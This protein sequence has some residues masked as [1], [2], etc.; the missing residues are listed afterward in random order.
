[1]HNKI[2]RNI[3]ILGF[4]SFFTDMASA[5]VTPLIPVFIVVVLHEG[6]DKLGL[7]VAMATLFS[8]LLRLFSGYISDRYGITKPLVVGGYILSAIS[9]PLLY[10]AHDWQSV[11]LIRSAERIGKGV[12]SA[13][14]DVMIAHYSQAK[15]EGKTFGFHKTL[16]IAGELSGALLIFFI[17]KWV[18]ESEEIIRILFLFTVI[19][20]IISIILMAFFVKD[21]PKTP[22]QE[23]GFRLTSKDHTVIK[24]MSLYFVFIFFAFSD[25][26]FTLRAIDLGFTVGVIPLFFIV[27]IGIQTLFSY[28]IGWLIDR[29]GYKTVFTISMIAG[30]LMQLLLYTGTTLSVWLAYGFFGLF[31]VASLNANRAFI[32]SDSDNKGSVYGIFYAGTALFASA[33]A[34]ISGLIWEE[35]GDISALTFSLTGTVTALFIY[36]I[37]SLKKKNQNI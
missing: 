27:S 8:Y 7:I 10:F 37:L 31:T 3:V 28:P 24:G 14:K 15:M 26:F 20:G 29:V 35:L 30:V 12:R 6:I 2:D 11:A 4:V 36:L 33:G 18:G 16:D 1:M 34:Y 13:P 9:K 5:M 17:L 23:S 32:S 19:P 22:E 25:S 21:V